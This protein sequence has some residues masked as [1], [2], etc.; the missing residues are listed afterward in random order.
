MAKGGGR[1]HTIDRDAAVAQ[2][3]KHMAAYS[4]SALVVM[5][6]DRPCGIFTE[7]DLVRCHLLF[8]EKEIGKIPVE[9][10]M[11]QSLVV[12]EPS[13]SV[14]DAMAMMIKAGIR[15]LPVVEIK[16]LLR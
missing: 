14:E 12:V 2:A 3:L 6:Q 7:R 13:D 8:A 11:T 10:V 5:D 9:T 15:H 4:V 1:F 16:R